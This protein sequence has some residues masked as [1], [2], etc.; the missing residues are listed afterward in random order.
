MPVI[1][2]R[3]PA[4]SSAATARNEVVV[5]PSVPVIPTTARSRLGSPYHQ[6]AAVA[7]AVR[8]S[9]DDELRQVDL[10]QRMLDEAA[11]APAEAAAET[12]S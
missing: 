9:A 8:L 5:L 4:A 10:G 3:M 1:P 2:V 12:Y 11:A 7:R 6:A